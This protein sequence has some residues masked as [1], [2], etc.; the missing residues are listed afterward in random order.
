MTHK[1]PMGSR[2]LNEQLL[3]TYIRSLMPT[4]E[5]GR[6]GVDKL[7][8]GE[9]QVGIAGG[10]K[11]VVSPALTFED[12][13]GHVGERRGED[14]DEIDDRFLCGSAPRVRR[15]TAHFRKMLIVSPKIVLTSR[16]DRKVGLQ[17]RWSS[18]VGGDDT[19]SQARLEQRT[20][21][22]RYKSATDE[23]LNPRLRTAEGHDDGRASSLDENLAPSVRRALEGRR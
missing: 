13:P 16:L 18:A 22:S 9:V 7:V 12:S 1:N 23:L 21:F 14:G 4:Q 11:P 17:V 20:L 19:S 6:P 10:H 5:Q 15:P 2:K 3:C 8:V